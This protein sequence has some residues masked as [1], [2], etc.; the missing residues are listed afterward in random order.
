[1]TEEMQKPDLEPFEAEI[2]IPPTEREALLD[3]VTTFQQSMQTLTRMVEQL[4]ADF[5]TKIKYD[6]SK[7]STIDALHRELQEYRGD[8]VF[9]ILRP[10][11]NDLLALY[12]DI[13]H[14]AARHGDES[15]LAKEMKAVQGDIAEI[16][17]RHGFEVFEAPDETY[18]SSVQRV[19]QVIETNESDRDHQIARRVRAGVL[20]GERLL[21]HEV[22]DIY[23]YRGDDEASVSVD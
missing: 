14:M 4:R 22:V 13:G 15:P 18:D 10:V 2:P 9:K 5:D 20:S 12:D 8:L 1:M 19:Q 23:R 6:Q 11:I 17:A 21:R 3:I 16:M 7:E